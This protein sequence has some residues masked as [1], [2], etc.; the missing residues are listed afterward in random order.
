MTPLFKGIKTSTQVVI[1]MTTCST[2]FALGMMPFLLYVY[3]RG[4]Y[5]GDLKS[6][7]PYKGI[8][9]SL[10]LV[11]IPCTIGIFLNAKRPQY[12]RYVHKGGRIVMLLLSVAI[13]ALSVIN[14]GKSIMCSRTV[15]METGCQNVQLCSTILNVTFPPEEIGPLFFFPLLYM[16]FQL[17]EGVLLIFIFRCYEKIKPSKDKTK[18]TYTAAEIE[19]TIPGTLGNGTHKGEKCSPCTAWSEDNSV[20][21][22][23]EQKM[24]E[25]QSLVSST[26]DLLTERDLLRLRL[27]LLDLLT[28]Y[29]EALQE[30][31][32]QLRD[33][34]TLST[35]WDRCNLALQT[36][37]KLGSQ[38]D[39]S[40]GPD[41]SNRNAHCRL[42]NCAAALSPRLFW[43]PPICRS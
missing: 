38:H 36:K 7:I 16:I 24:K 25:H 32:S 27:L 28:S 41:R 26:G 15:S 22:T 5:D 17:G 18:M 6:K 12:V 10:V 20:Q 43:P 3:S 9:V 34:I 39:P 19:E 33:Q 35:L 29:S 2:F 1:V 30:D 14:V 42:W 13:I 4:I 37:L 23:G 21:S 40:L 11:L 8:V 31:S